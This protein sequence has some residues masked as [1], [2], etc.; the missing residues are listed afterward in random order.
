MKFLNHLNEVEERTYTIE[1]VVKALKRKC[2]KFLKETAP[3]IK[4]GDFI[5]RGS[6]NQIS[7]GTFIDRRLSRLTDRM[8]MSTSIEVHNMLNDMF[9]KK[10]GWQ[11]RNGVFASDVGQSAGYGVAYSFFPI[12]DYKY[13]WS[14]AV[15]DLFSTINMLK[16]Y[17]ESLLRPDTPERLVSSLGYLRMFY[18]NIK[19]TVGADFNRPGV[20]PS[21]ANIPKALQA[22]INSYRGSGLNEA[23]SEQNEVSFECKEYYL[24]DPE[25]WSTISAIEVQQYLDKLAS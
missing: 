12:G 20:E 8:P 15:G 17:Y 11:V 18:S 16:Y 24:V 9:K 4:K 25:I 6:D 19:E 1:K 7:H 3:S 14:P 2:G 23:I 13:C 10:F 5:Y 21:P 22:L